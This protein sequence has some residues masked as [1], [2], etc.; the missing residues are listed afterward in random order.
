MASPLPFLTRQDKIVLESLQDDITAGERAREN[1]A[2]DD[3]RIEQLAAMADSSDERFEPTVFTGYD[4]QWDT[5]DPMLLTL[6]KKYLLR[7]YINWA[8]T[9]V[10][11][12]TDVVFLTHILLYISILPLSAAILFYRFT[13]IHAVLHGVMVGASCGPF[14]LLLHNHIHNGGILNRSYAWFDHAFPYILEPLLGHTWDSYYYHHVKHHHV[15]GN[16][17][18]DL[19]STIRYQRDELLDFLIY[20]G[21]FLLLIWIELPLYFYRKGQ[22]RMAAQSFFSEQLSYFTIFALSRVNFRATMVTLLVPLILMRIGM[23]V[24]NW[25]QHALVDEIDPDSD[26]R[27]S[28][29]LIDVPS[30][31]FCF[32]DGYHTSHHLNPRRHWRDHPISFLKAKNKYSAEG[33]LVFQNIDYLMM[34]YHL[35]RKDYDH[36]A[37]CLIPIGDQI[38]KSPEELAAL[39]RTKT[40]RF[41]EEDIQ[42]KYRKTVSK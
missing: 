28:I 15:E 3:A 35:I 16:G 27:S 5:K 21:R 38:G 24:G 31:R 23:M 26:F 4:L 9:V 7:P 34:T 2:A 12:P 17:P 14:T 13:W 18:G 6:V 1:V 11:R 30:N 42:R 10:R 22:L 29:T 33:A 32:N 39:L 40:R 36:L 8:Q 37:T 20:T 41:T 19:S 25:G